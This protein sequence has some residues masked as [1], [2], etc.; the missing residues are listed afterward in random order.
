MYNLI[1]DQIG[2]LSL[3]LNLI[4]DVLSGLCNNELDISCLKQIVHKQLPSRG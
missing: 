4:C 3:Q 1:L 2:T